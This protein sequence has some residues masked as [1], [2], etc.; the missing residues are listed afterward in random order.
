MSFAKC[1]KKS[2]PLL[3][4]TS[5]CFSGLIV[6][7]AFAEIT[8]TVCKSL[9][10]VADAEGE[11]SPAVTV[12][13][14]KAENGTTL[15]MTMAGTSDYYGVGPNTSGVASTAKID[16]DDNADPERG[17]VFYGSA[18]TGRVTIGGLNWL[19]SRTSGGDFTASDDEYQGDPGKFVDDVLNGGKKQIGSDVLNKVRYVPAS[20]GTTIPGVHCNEGN[21][22]FCDR[23]SME[24]FLNAILAAGYR[25]D[26]CRWVP[27]GSDWD[28]VN[29]STI[30]SLVCGG[31]PAS[32][33]EI[34]YTLEV[35]TE[36]NETAQEV[37]EA[38][39]ENG[40][41]QQGTSDN[42]KSVK[43]LCY[44]TGVDDQGWFLCPSLANMT[45]TATGMDVL[46]QDWLSVDS[47]LYD[48]GSDTY[49]VWEIMRNI[50]N[51]LMIILLLVVIFSQLTGYGIDNYGIKKMLPRLITMAILIN[52]SFVI[53]EL[54]VDLSN[55]LGV[56]LRNMFG[57][58]GNALDSQYSFNGKDFISGV[59]E[60]IFGLTIGGGAVAGV[61]VE[62]VLVGGPMGVV[63][64][65]LAL[66]SVIAALLLFFIALA[67]R[68]II[69]ILCIAV[70]P[71]AFAMF[72][73]PN[74]QNIFKKWWDIF[75][76]ALIM[77]PI[78]GALGGISALIKGMVRSDGSIMMLVI[79]LIAPFLVFFLL[80][81]LL[82]SM[83]G[84]LGQIGGAL[85]TMG[86]S[87]TGGA[88]N[89]T[90]AVQN[91]D[92]FQYAKDSAMTDRARRVRDTMKQRM[93]NGE[94]LSG[95]QMS[96]FNRANRRVTEWD[97]GQRK[98]YADMYGELG[99]DDLYRLA[100]GQMNADG[101]VQT[102]ANGNAV[103]KSLDW[104]N[105]PGGEQRMSALIGAMESRGMESG[106]YSMLRQNNVSGMAGVM[107]S[108]ASSNNKVLKAYG[109]RGGDTDFSSFMT[110]TGSNSLRGYAESKGSDFVSGLD[111]KSLAEIRKADEASM[112]AGNGHV[113]ETSQLVQAAA[114]LNDADS[115]KE[116]NAMLAQR[117]DASISGEQ[118]ASFDSSTID[119]MM[120]NKGSAQEAAVIRASSDLARNTQLVNKLSGTSKDKINARRAEL[121]AA[122]PS[123]Q[124]YYLDL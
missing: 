86:Q 48:S 29:Y 104:L 55:I 39:E 22:L 25:A 16:V 15:L 44:D 2:W 57:A 63:I 110:G 118:L 20:G 53:C 72:I 12:C 109:K 47:D 88:R 56:G 35:V 114:Q 61:V 13:A 64:I 112:A 111:D 89:V 98:A 119:A 24:N 52:L 87:F 27:D 100:G 21:G 46:I 4:L 26:D 49:V 92:R 42:V 58:I 18:G 121:R 69:I 120:A 78:C 14:G 62:A 70:A 84:M 73:L 122:D 77:F 60:A 51:A 71:V 80:P 105:Q 19:D 90:G 117:D 96:Q 8:D 38:V 102:D 65:L 81:M 82:K 107:N 79:G 31:E 95:R 94:R 75:K 108:L 59:V 40:G 99:R 101:T 123:N 97:N 43:D 103:F 3:I 7:N 113:M 116:V 11:W 37:A 85:Q 68:M 124:D 115:L 74:T 83:I 54:A 91:S 93:A 5:F 9:V 34:T 106:V 23:D 32:T 76:V 28:G 33:Y 17:A 41:V 66:I 50:A 10:A 30:Y 36:D 45:Y 1:F 67:A 6:N